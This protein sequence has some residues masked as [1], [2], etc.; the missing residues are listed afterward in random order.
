MVFDATSST[1]IE[2][3]DD[4]GAFSVLS[5]PLLGWSGRSWGRESRRELRVYCEDRDKYSDGASNEA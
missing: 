5:I 4:A 3:R 1:D 2:V